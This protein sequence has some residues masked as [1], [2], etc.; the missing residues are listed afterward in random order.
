ML[1]LVTE[2]SRKRRTARVEQH[3]AHYLCSTDSAVKSQPIFTGKVH[4][5]NATTDFVVKDGCVEFDV[6]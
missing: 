3:T 5:P 4:D 2:P 6:N 1:I